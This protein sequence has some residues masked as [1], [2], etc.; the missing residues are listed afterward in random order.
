MVRRSRFRES[1]NGSDVPLTETTGTEAMTR[2]T[3]TFHKLASRTKKM[4]I[5]I[6]IDKKGG[7]FLPNGE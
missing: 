3:E 2:K 7:V 6:G 5:L 4:K 1:G